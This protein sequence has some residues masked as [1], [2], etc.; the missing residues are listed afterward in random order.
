MNDQNSQT[1]PGSAAPGARQQI[2]KG[3]LGEAC[4]VFTIALFFYCV[5]YTFQEVPA[6]LSAG[7]PPHL[8]PRALL[9][10]VMVLSAING[11]KAY[12]G[13]IGTKKQ[14]KAPPRIVFIT[15]GILTLFVIGLYTVGAIISTFIFCMVL[16]IIWGERRYGP[17]LI[18]FS[19]FTGGVYLL[20]EIILGANLP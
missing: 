14:F 19:L 7:I 12:R 3:E 8:F 16:A 4:I 11:V 5:T 10:I 2:H 1:N 20:F 15:A 6:A 9:L 17:L 18:T 13:T